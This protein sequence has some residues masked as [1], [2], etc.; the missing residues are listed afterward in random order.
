LLIIAQVLWERTIYLLFVTFVTGALVIKYILLTSRN[1]DIRY[2]F[3]GYVFTLFEFQ[4]S[5]NLF[6][7]QWWFYLLLKHSISPL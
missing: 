3:S 5:R 1:V 2:I 6:C 4:I 7:N